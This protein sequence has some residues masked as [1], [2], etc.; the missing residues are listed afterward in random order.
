[1]SVEQIRHDVEEELRWEARID[2]LA[3]GVAGVVDRIVVGS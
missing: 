1:M 3:P 2:H